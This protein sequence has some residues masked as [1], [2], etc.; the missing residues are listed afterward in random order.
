MANFSL[1]KSFII[2]TRFYL[3]IISS[4][5]YSGSCYKDEAAT[6]ESPAP[7]ASCFSVLKMTS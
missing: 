5:V 6:A 3:S 4:V 1:S 2:F 7:F